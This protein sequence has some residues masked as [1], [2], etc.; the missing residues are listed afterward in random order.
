[1]GSPVNEHQ[2]AKVD[3][4]PRALRDREHGVADVNCVDEGDD[5]ARQ[6]EVPEDD[7]D[8]ADLLPLRRDPLHDESRPEE[9]LAGQAEGDPEVPVPTCH[10]HTTRLLGWRTTIT[11]SPALRTSTSSSPSI[12]LLRRAMDGEEDGKGAG[13]GER[14]MSGVHRS[15]RKKR[16]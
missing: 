4:Q 7:G 13:E 15:S 9:E 11:R 12:A 2:V 3:D 5:A 1:M 6:G 10:A 16:T 8:V 14:V